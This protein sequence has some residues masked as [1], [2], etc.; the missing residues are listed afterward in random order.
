[1]ADDLKF[2]TWTSYW[3]PVA[4]VS[5]PMP[6]G[7]N[8]NST[9]YGFENV[10]PE[11]QGRSHGEIQEGTG[12]IF[13]YVTQGEATV[14]DIHGAQ[15]IHAGEYFVVP[16]PAL[17]TVAPDSRLVAIH[18]EPFTPIRTFGGPIEDKGRLRYIDGCSDSLLIGPPMLEDPC[19]NLLHFPPGIHQT[20]HTHPSIRT[21][22][23]VSGAGYCVDGD[24]HREDLLPGMIW[25][26]PKETVHAFHTEDDNLNVLAFH[27]DTDFGPEN[28]EHPML[29][30]TWVDGEKIDNTTERHLNPDILITEQIIAR[31]DATL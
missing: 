11:H 18:T 30:R 17:F 25:V 12:A 2:S 29:N 31:R 28:E 5:D 9:V 26:I 3:G 14:A 7:Y 4:S 13:G 15:T 19:L 10:S 16:A 27:P 20:R 21:G 24:D 8:R 22:A 1:M 23:I 6:T